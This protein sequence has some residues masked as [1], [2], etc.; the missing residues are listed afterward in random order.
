M[1]D[2]IGLV[3]MLGV[4][5][6]VVLQWILARRWKGGWRIAALA[7]L[8][9]MI[10]VLGHAL[11]AL[12]AQSNLWPIFVIFTAPVAFAYLVALIVL[13]AGVRWVQG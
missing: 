12:A 1:G 13:W 10:P 7:P 9:I 6:Y 5:G 3:I 4:P 2:P 11:L 8:V